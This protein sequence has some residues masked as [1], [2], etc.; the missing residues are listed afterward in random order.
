MK[1]ARTG[2][3][4]AVDVIGR[5]SDLLGIIPQ[6]PHTRTA[7]QISARLTE[8]GFD[9][10]KRSVERDLIKLEEAKK[11]GIVRNADKKRPYAWSRFREATDNMHGLDHPTALTLKLAYAYVRH[12]V[13]ASVLGDLK[14]LA[15]T[16]DKSLE[17]IRH[18]LL[19]RWPDKIRVLSSGPPRT[20]P[21]VAPDVHLAVSEA[22]LKNRQLR[23][24]YPR[25]DETTKDRLVN[26]LGMVVK[27]GVIYLVVSG[28]KQDA[29][30]NLALHRIL[31]AHME[32]AD[33]K[34]PSGWKGLDAY[35]DAGNLLF[36]LGP[37]KK[38]CQVTLRFDSIFVR[39][40]REMPIS[41]D[42]SV[43]KDVKSASDGKP[44]Y[45]V[46]AR[47]TVSEEF[48]RWLLQYGE[49]VEVIKPQ[50]LRRR[51]RSIIRNLHLRYDEAFEV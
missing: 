1:K 14:R 28:E 7:Q 12:L 17:G 42:Q 44:Y 33:V 26:P 10:S 34:P 18:N 36:P 24:R 32:Y 23:L 37:S 20:P 21:R 49:H 15:D 6:L 51:V 13:P 11:F 30:Y 2:R 8:K 48:V 19:A 16:A 25:G 39:N 31:E 46:R 40:I 22:L 3:S 47:V 45:L 29:P 43:K 5:H 50:H 9:V 35:I 41:G 38:D 27:G 4:R